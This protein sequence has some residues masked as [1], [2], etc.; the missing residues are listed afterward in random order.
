MKLIVVAA[1]LLCALCAQ[2]QETEQDGDLKLLLEDSQLG[3]GAETQAGQRGFSVKGIVKKA[4]DLTKRAKDAAAKAASAAK[5]A[6]GGRRGGS[7]K[8]SRPSFGKKFSLKSFGKKISSHAKKIA[9]SAR[10]A[11]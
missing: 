3:E 8:M 5:K 6:A 7:V 9:S 2:A 11:V 1:L 10:K 4:L